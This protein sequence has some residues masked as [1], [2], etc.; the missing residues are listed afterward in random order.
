MNTKKAVVFALALVA[1]V[2]VGAPI[3]SFC[4]ACTPAATQAVAQGVATIAGDVCQVVAQDD[5]NVPSWFQVACKIEGQAAPL[6][7]V[8]SADAWALAQKS[9]SKKVPAKLLSG[10]SSDAGTAGAGG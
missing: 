9:S 3:A 1:V 10:A 5:P 8:V 7:A 6:V 4:T 2:F